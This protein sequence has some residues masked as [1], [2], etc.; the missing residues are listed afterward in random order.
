MKAYK[1]NIYSIL[2]ISLWSFLLFS[3]RE[4]DTTVASS[5]D[6]LQI[7]LQANNNKDQVLIS[8]PILILQGKFLADNNDLFFAV[9][10]REVTSNTQLTITAES[11]TSFIE[12]YKK[13]YGKTLPLLPSG[14]YSIQETINIPAGKS[15]S[16][17]ML[18]LTWKDPS[19]IKDKNA[20]YLLPVSI[21]SM[22]NKNATLTSNR[23]TIFIEV[24]FSEVS[25]SF[26]T[27]AG[28]TTDDVIF[29]KA[30]NIVLINGANPKLSVSLN[31]IINTETLIK[32]GVDNSLI[33]AY[34]N[35]NGT[36]FQMLPENTYK[37][38][39]ASLNI[40][41]G[42]TLSNEL[43]I[44]FTDAMAQLD[45]QKQYL[46]PV[47]SSMQSGLP[48]TN[49]I[50]YLKINIF[51]TNFNSGTPVVG[52]TIDRSNWSVTT[53]SEYQP[54]YNA[55]MMLDGDTNTGWLSGLNS[56]AVTLDM[57]T[58]H[59]LKGFSLTPTYFNGSY[60]LFSQN[61]TV[62]TS[63]D[64]INWTKQGAYENNE[65]IGGSPQAPYIGWISFIEPVRT[66]YVKFDNIS[67]LQGIGEFNAIE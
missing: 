62:Y 51:I 13:Q 67:S 56:S 5:K 25:Y 58:I 1:I 9:A 41:K 8:T 23:N 26:K 66:R 42:K 49:D 17:K 21:K 11:D 47:K 6:A 65:N 27:L 39:T 50:V 34:N 12:A 31:S 10:T 44:Q 19:L 60:A 40:A 61:F 20:T 29:K 3:C 33:G 64:G 52:S 4:D 38:S 14:A 54:E 46:L 55:S 45:T 2:F 22:D 36:Q 63:D 43:E 48:T 15:M 59:T 37:L 18:S 53:S 28:K 16:D 24:K 32:V 35:T 30:G 7:Y 57:G